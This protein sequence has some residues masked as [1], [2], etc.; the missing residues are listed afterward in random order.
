MIKTSTTLYSTQF[1][2]GKGQ[3]LHATVSSVEKGRVKACAGCVQFVLNSKNAHYWSA[4]EH[5]AKK[6]LMKVKG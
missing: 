6:Q 4:D 3:P 2:F 1:T 5:Y